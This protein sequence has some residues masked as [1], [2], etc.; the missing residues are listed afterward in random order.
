MEAA[1]AFPRE[2]NPIG[3]ARCRPRLGQPDSAATAGAARFADP[4][5]R[6]LVAN[7]NLTTPALEAA[8]GTTLRVRV[9]RQDIMSADRL[10]DTVRAPLQLPSGT[11]VMV[12]RSCLL[13]PD[14]IPV[15]VN[16]VVSAVGV[17]AQHKLDSVDTAIG[18][19]LQARQ[20]AQRRELLRAG[21]ARWPD[22][23]VCASR[24]YI[25]RVEAGPLCY[26]R[27]SFN[28]GLISP[29]LL[30]EHPELPW[31]DEPVSPSR[32][33]G[34]STTVSPWL[35]A[36]STGADQLRELPPLVSADECDTLTSELAMVTAGQAFAL[37]MGNHVDTLAN[38][39][40]DMLIAGQAMA[41]AAAAVLAFGS[42]RRIVTISRIADQRARPWSAPNP[43]PQELLSRY[44]HA[45]A[46]FNHLRTHPVA[47]PAPA[48]ALLDQAADA[49]PN[50][51][52][53][54]LLRNVADMFAGA[55]TAPAGGRQVHS[56]VPR[57]WTSH[58]ALLPYTPALTRRGDDGRWWA[59][60]AHL[61]RI[62][63]HTDNEA[64][65]RLVTAIGNPIA[66]TVGPTAEPDDIAALCL[67]LNPDRTPG[68]LTLIA[69]LD[70]A[71]LPP[72]LAAVMATGVPV[73]W[74]CDPI[75]ATTGR[76]GHGRETTD[77]EAIAVEIHGFFDA[78][79]RTGAIPGG[80]RL[81]SSRRLNP[82]QALH[83]V[84]IAHH[85]LHAL[86]SIAS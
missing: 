72:L 38:R 7:T 25:M 22:Q 11:E 78:C 49:C 57:L 31:D 65:L 50:P 84:T 55:T 27:E 80:L 1:T 61:L 71:L 42:G 47:P 16:Y 81:A 43:D 73:A 76:S 20:V 40:A 59:G 85:E 45:A 63:H 67:R 6:M 15:S 34:E 58:E 21:L 28:P 23:R 83:C 66:V 18:H 33:A 86:P 14:S 82:A 56:L 10:P 52:S 32:W 39:R 24:S 35:D 30:V 68:R 12:R 13:D 19:S 46:T 54:D 9:L 41:A 62:G 51:L 74:V 70:T 8:L 75:P 37:H 3:T 4:T 44:L 60:S 77:F 2:K 69:R 26:I 79:R 53:A 5:T 36:A 64:R 17:G 29:E 48:V